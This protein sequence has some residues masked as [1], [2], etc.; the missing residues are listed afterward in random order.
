M[1]PAGRLPVQQRIHHAGGGVVGR[2]VAAVDDDVGFG[3]DRIALLHQAAQRLL[4]ITAV[5]QRAVVAGGDTA[6]QSRQGAA[7][8]D[9]N[10][11]GSGRFA[12]L[13][14]HEGAAT[15]CQDHRI[16]GQQ[17]ADHPALTVAERRLAITCEQFG[18][19]A[20]RGQ[21]DLLVGVAKR[22]AQARGQAAPD[23]RLAGA[24]KADQYDAAAGDR[25][26]NWNR[27]PKSSVACHNSGR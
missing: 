16:A 5:E 19:G 8:P 24:H 10:C 22:Q 27:L 3:I 12:R 23:R 26:G 2:F 21:L 4:A 17:A 9:G 6:N 14:V 15:E 13:R 1:Q 11:F 18:D 7:Q 20:A 25:V